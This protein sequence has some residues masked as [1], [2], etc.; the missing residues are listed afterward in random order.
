M[1]IISL[2][3]NDRCSLRCRDWLWGW[4]NIRFRLN[5]HF[6]MLKTISWGWFIAIDHNDWMLDLA[7]LTVNWTDTTFDLADWK[8]EKSDQTLYNFN[9][10][11]DYADK[12]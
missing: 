12:H 11:L 8:W 4:L 1:E 10:F 2:K 9:M 3:Y 7:D 6:L 5:Q